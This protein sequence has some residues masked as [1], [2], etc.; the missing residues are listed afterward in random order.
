MKTSM[1]MTG[2]RELGAAMKELDSRVQKRI[3]RSATAAGARVIANEAKKLVPVDTGNLKKNIRTAN[4]KP[5]QPGLQETVV[6]VRVKGKKDDSAYYF[7]FLEFGTA[8]MA[9]RPF[10]RP[11][12]ETKKQEAAGK[13]KEQL[14]KRLEAEAQKIGSATVRNK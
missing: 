3:A 11:A 10:L 9:P 13:I 8:H 14:A 6:G 1:Q 7:R 2:L 4:L 5:N 12:F